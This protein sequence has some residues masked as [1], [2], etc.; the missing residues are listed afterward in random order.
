MLARSPYKTAEELGI[1]EAAHKGLLKVLD[2]LKKDEL[3]WVPLGLPTIKNGFN[4][5]TLWDECPDCGTIGCISGWAS[6]FGN[7]DAMDASQIAIGYTKQHL[8]AWEDLTCPIGWQSG[9]HTVA[10]AE[11]A[12][13]SYLLTG[14]ADW[15]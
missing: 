14:K 11:V 2:M 6:F 7:K 12:L 15:S 1:T 10:Q 3:V 4:M 9:K 5:G 13:E 8:A